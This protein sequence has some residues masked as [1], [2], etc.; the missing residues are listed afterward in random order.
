[1]LFPEA[2]GAGTALLLS[3]DGERLP[4]V[5]WV[6]VG[7]DVGA[8]GFGPGTGPGAPLLVE[9]ARNSFARPGLRG[10]RLAPGPFV[11]SRDVAGRDW[12]PQFT[13]TGV[14]AEA[15]ALVIRATAGPAGLALRTEVEALAG[16]PLRI[17][18]T[19][20]NGGTTPYLL[21]GLEVTVPLADRHTEMLDFTGRHQLERV[22][23]RAPVRDGL[24]LRES[25]QGRPGLDAASILV[26]GQAG[27]GFA[28]GECLAVHVAHSG[29][30]VLRLERSA[31]EGATIGGGELLWPGEVV[32]RPGESY[33]SP[34]VVVVASSA[35][36]DPIAH[37]LHRWQRSLA[38]HP[39]VQPVT[40]N[41]WE[42]V[43]FD[44]DRDRLGELAERAARVGV[45]RFVL[46][47]GWFRGRRDDTAGLGDWAV[48]PAVWPDGLDPLIDHVH[49]LGLQFGLWFEPEMVNPDSELYRTHPD[50]ILATDDRVPILRRNQLVLDLSRNEVWTMLRD[51]IDEL[52]RAHRIDYVKWD[53]NRE[54]LDAGSGHHGGAPAA[55]RNAEAF[56]ALLD[57]LAARHPNVA[58][59]SCASGG[60]RIDLGVIERVQRFWTSDMTD[61]LARHHIQRWTAQ[62]IAPEYLGAHVSAPVAHQTGRTFSLDFRAATALFY[63]FGIEW[64]LTAAT[65][66]ELDRLAEWV[67][68][69]K[70]FRPL[71]HS[72][73]LRRL[74]LADPAG[75]SYATLAPD[76]SAALLAHVQL[77]ESASNRGTTLRLPGLVPDA[78]YR[79]EF[80]GPSEHPD[81]SLP[82]LSG[83]ALARVGVW[84]PRRPPETVV[85]ISL[86]RV[87]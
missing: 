62:F 69:H 48:D 35:G 50:W 63:A 21:D 18:H 5:Q 2:A 8:A 14:D 70:R 32:L 56:Y 42:A 86:G 31:A 25:R 52:L 29:N 4:V 26:A 39:S 79:L 40:L 51:R 55:H 83:A 24:W 20:A 45:E 47:D 33:T 23:Q 17:R 6:G 27:F 75:L 13:V 87:D 9:H 22:P 81:L 76:A 28:D 80:A 57:D 74:D 16:G 30:S 1:V 15:T 64:D 65:E 78:T 46:D 54:L 71:L 60:G 72:G 61:A 82:T 59:E 34:W 77:G 38:A 3:T 36:L 37:A 53:H 49:A 43:Y 19:V 66:A 73:V 68:L 41:V 85:L 84:L 7:N 12:S 11:D 10:H 67:A 44:H 58:W